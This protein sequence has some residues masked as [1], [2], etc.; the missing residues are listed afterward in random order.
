MKKAFHGIPLMLLLALAAAVRLALAWKAHVPTLDTAVVGQMAV[1]ILHGD[2]PLFF[3]GQ[4][5]MGALE[6]Y[7]LAGVF[8]LLPP[9]RVTMTLATIGFALLWITATY[10]F[11]RKDFGR[12]AALAAALVPAFPGWSGIWY[13]TVPYGGY[14]E[15]YALGM[16]LMILGRRVLPPGEA[17][18]SW[19]HAL[20]FSFVTALGVWTNLQILP[21]LGAA[22]FALAL[23]FVR[24]RGQPWKGWLPYALIP[25]AVLLAFLPQF[26]AES[27]H[28]QPPLFNG[29]SFKAIGR[30]WAALW[31]YDLPQC[32]LWTF[33][34]SM[35][36][37]LFAALMFGLVGGG[38]VM[39]MVRRRRGAAGV[40]AGMAMCGIMLLVFAVTYFPHPM[41]GRVPRYLIAPVALMMS[42]AIATW[43]A[44][45]RAMIRRIGYAAA[46]LLAAYHVYGTLRAASIRETEAR[47]T[48]SDFSATIE[49]VRQA[50]WDAVLH[51][52][53]E[54]E[55]YDGAR[56]HFLAD[57]KPS[58]ASAYSDRFL[59]HQRAWE[60]ADRRG[61]MSRYR[62]LPF[63]R[64]SLDAM[65]VPVG[66][67]NTNAPYAL[68]ESPEVAR[69]IERV[70][71]PDRIEE[72]DGAPEA[73]PLFDRSAQTAWPASGET[74]SPPVVRVFWDAPARINGLRISAP[75]TPELPSRYT[76]RVR[77]ERGVWTVAQQCDRRIAGS[78]ISGTSV[79]VR[80]HHPWM[81]IR[82]PPADATALEFT[83]FPGSEY[84]TPWR[85]CDLRILES[86]GEPWPELDPA[87]KTILQSVEEH[88][89]ARVV[90]ERGLARRLHRYA[91]AHNIPPEI[92]GR[93]PLPY[94]PR[95]SRTQPEQMP[96]AAG[97]YLM[98][99]EE[100]YLDPALDTLRQAHL[101]VQSA[102]RVSP[103]GLIRFE[104]SD[105]QKN[106]IEW[107]GYT[108][109]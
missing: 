4:N 31:S 73:H 18:P 5:Y 11:F 98:V 91:S 62:A 61:F 17:E 26:F 13:T 46:I 94:N 23:A 29:M 93:L 16:L 42:A 83:L 53:S 90:C 22:G 87:L 7:A 2:R 45:P 28:V 56:L 21:Y 38:V 6:A 15:T 74:A 20:L 89:S 10:F 66:F 106:R 88:P 30:S 101:S 79:Y 72:W 24:R 25:A 77:D 40:P 95:F 43:A 67:I 34:P 102:M 64:G 107:R 75:S 55:G 35:L 14:P 8:A 70:R 49:A 37:V 92:Q 76:V 47:Q 100:A 44:S 51:S 80:G 71:P 85:L 41:S 9:G 60:F 54:T 69:M 32:M 27:S 19:K 108:V 48:F 99:V 105:S 103:Y 63:L 68:I 12:P 1:D 59:D 33:P 36:H 104:I 65:Q 82:F 39:M 52:G 58:F 3:A 57:G 84:S 81:D 50:G 97:A 96:L 78:Y 86:S 109:Y